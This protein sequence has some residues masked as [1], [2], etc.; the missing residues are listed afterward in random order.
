M[1]AIDA[2][3]SAGFRLNQGGRRHYPGG[4]G[5]Q[6]DGELSTLRGLGS[7][8]RVAVLELRVDRACEN[9]EGPSARL[10]HDEVRA[11]FF[12]NCMEILSHPRVNDL[13]LRKWVTSRTETA[14]CDRGGD[15]NG[16]FY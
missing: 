11:L 12:F 6:V 8:E 16:K 5:H 15:H 14:R 7:R 4:V 3:D 9:D 13:N 1:V 2:I 10:Q